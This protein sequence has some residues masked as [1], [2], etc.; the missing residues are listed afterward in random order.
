MNLKH[1]QK[2]EQILQLLKDGSLLTAT[3]ICEKL[4]HIDRAT[5]YRNLDLFTRQGFLRKVNVKEGVASYEITHEGDNHQ[6]FICSNCEK[7]IPIDIDKHMIEKLAPKGV[8]L[9]NF[10][11]NVKGKCEDCK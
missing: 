1:S 3:E 6:H 2:R 8:K 5:I 9:E 11:L 4:P 7:I 10:E